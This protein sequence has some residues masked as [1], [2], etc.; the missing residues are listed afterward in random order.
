[1]KKAFLSLLAFLLCLPAF[2]QNEG[3]RFR[4]IDSLMNY[5]YT[6]NKFMGALSIREKDNLVF[7]RA[8]G[9]ADLQSRLP[10]N[11]DTKYK[12]GGITQMFT[13]AI[14]FQLVDEKKL[15]LETKLSE[16]FPKIKDAEKITVGSLLNHK[17]GIYNFTAD[18]LFKSYNTKPQL[19]KDMLDRLYAHEPGFEPGT[20]AEYSDANY[21]LLG[22]I[23]QDVTKKTYKENVTL[24]IIKRL[25]LKNTYYF[26]KISP[27]KNE[28]YS[29][30]PAGGK[31]QKQEE[32]N[33]GVAGAANGL[34]STPADLTKFA[35]ALFSGKLL[36][37]A[38]MAQLT[39][40]D[41]GYGRGVFNF[42]F[43][44]R[45]FTGHNGSI[46]GFTSVLG[47]Y[48]KEELSF[49]LALNAQNCDFNEL[50]LGILSCYYKLPY[51]FPNFKTVVI[52][53]HILKSYEGNYANAKLPFTINVKVVDGRLRV[54]ADEQGTFYLNAISATEFNHDASGVVMVFSSK[55][56]IL[57]QNGAE[58]FFTKQ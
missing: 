46:E 4:K 5:Y 17:S 28:A 44:E 27:K 57:K 39:Q 15:T 58:T 31:W 42:S 24:R 7:N 21:L 43:A 8:Y 9:Y 54:H 51:R 35:R 45:K 37:P 41:M 18:S 40:I 23:I 47:Y 3:A 6:N 33:E 11:E 32:W 48:P 34:Q 52:E 29:Y 30:M 19:R 14:I 12:I 50:V 20:R 55:G 36:K 38:S 16:F 53:D 10:A 49:S 22:Y 25:G 26:N 56:F 2:S 1:M 13:S